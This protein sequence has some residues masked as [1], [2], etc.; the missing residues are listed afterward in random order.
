[1]QI[2]SKKQLAE[3][4]LPEKINLAKASVQNGNYGYHCQTV[5]MLNALRI[6][7]ASGDSRA[8]NLSLQ[9]AR[10]IIADTQKEISSHW[11][12]D[13]NTPDG[14]NMNLAGAIIL[15]QLNIPYGEY[16]IKERILRN[17]EPDSLFDFDNLYYVLQN[18]KEGK[19]GTWSFSYPRNGVISAHA[20]TVYA[21]E[22][23]SSYQEFINLMSSNTDTNTFSEQIQRLLP[24][25]GQL[26]FYEQDGNIQHSSVSIHDLMSFDPMSF[27][28]GSRF[29]IIDGNPPKKDETIGVLQSA[30]EAGWVHLLLLPPDRRKYLSLRTPQEKKQF[31]NQI[32]AEIKAQE[33]TRV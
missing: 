10:N 29:R 12:Q 22:A 3:Y 8:K 23:G 32:I 4:T 6:L 33:Y 25:I 13:G 21:F 26:R 5:A 19:V 1:M 7:E 27:Y 9:E 20:R 14:M 31:L 18:L 24:N 16:A 30:H 2:P 17:G 15:N 28:K 11:R